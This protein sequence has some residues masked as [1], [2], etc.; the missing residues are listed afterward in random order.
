[1][2][3]TD[4]PLLER[5]PERVR[6]VPV[7]AHGRY[8]ARKY[9]HP[10][11]KVALFAFRDGPLEAV[12]KAR[13]KLM[14]R[15]IE[16]AQMILVCA[17]SDDGEQR[18]GITRDVG[19][20][21]RFHT[22]LVFAAPD[23]LSIDH[24]HLTDDAI[25]ALE[26]YLPVPECP[27]ADRVA[28]AVRA[29]NPGLAGLDPADAANLVD[30][31]DAATDAHPAGPAHAADDADPAHA[32][33]RFPRGSHSGEGTGGVFL[34]GY[35]GYVREQILPRFRAEVVGATDHKT[36]LLR[37]AHQGDFP[38]FR[39]LADL[40]PAIAAAHRPLVIVATY[41]SDHVASAV[42]VLDANPGA[43]VFIEK[44]AA[45]TVADA[46][47]LLERRAAGAWIDI[48][49]NRRYAAMTAELAVAAQRL[50]RP[51]VFSALVKEL[52]LPASHWY[53]WPNQGTRVTGN[54]CHW[55]D[56]AH[57]LVGAPCKEVQAVGSPGSDETVSATLR[58]QDGS[59]AALVA[60]D[61]GDDL[62]GVTEYLE[63][64]GGGT[65]LVVDD[66]RRLVE[67]EDGRRRLRRHR[68]EKGHARMYRELRRRWLEDA[69]PAY[70]AADIVAVT[71]TTARVVEAV[72]SAAA[73]AAKAA[74]ATSP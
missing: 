15:R 36:E 34:L 45:V 9:R 52:K 72:A 13:S 44:P 43:R 35:G 27:L 58:F 60:T 73:G 59:I 74:G 18:I 40:L 30:A 31:A 38:L 41:H 24:V 63:L 5:S 48:G 22:E 67:L 65:T 51:L 64:R 6:R 21:P 54:L 12:R 14:E 19:G 61:A 50:P 1:V 47:V 62:G 66:Y 26:A 11:R 8:H 2:T 39:D 20:T 37:E 70:P 42:A 53:G 3:S 55:I 23:T 29:A 71:S 33:G 57:H 28:R 49:F 7:A 32:R 68:R 4:A 10:L 25:A 16:A 46:E 17:W 56:L 69:E